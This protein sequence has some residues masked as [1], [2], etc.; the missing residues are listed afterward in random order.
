MNPSSA[1]LIALAAL[2]APGARGAGTLS[3][4]S[5]SFGGAHT[6]SVTGG[7]TVSFVAQTPMPAGALRVVLTLPS[8]G[9][10]D[11]PRGWS[12]PASPTVSFSAPSGLLVPAGGASWD[13]AA[14]R[15]RVNTT[16]AA[17]AAD[18]TVT[19]TIS[20]VV[21]PAAA[22]VFATNGT[23][24]TLL[25]NSSSSSSSA[26]HADALADG[27]ATLAAGASPIV[28]GALTGPPQW[29]MQ[30]EGEQRP[31]LAGR[32]LRVAFTA[33]SPV[34]AGGFV[35]ATLGRDDG[36]QLA[37]GFACQLGGVAQPA[38][39]DAKLRTLRVGPLTAPG[40]GAGAAAV[41]SLTGAATPV[42]VKA[43]DGSG[44]VAT[45]SPADAAIDGPSALVVP[46]VTAG[47]LVGAPTWE[48]AAAGA[49]TPGRS[50]GTLRVTFTTAGA[51]G[52]GGFVVATLSRDD[53]W[54]LAAG[55]ACQ[56]GGVA[57]PA[58]WDAKNRTLRVGPLT[59][60][61]IGAGAA[62][63]LS[64]TGAATPA[65]VT[66]A[67]AAGSV[68]TR[69]AADGVV[70]GP[71]ALT[72]PA[73]TAGAL[74]TAAEWEMAAGTHTPG[75][76]NG[77][78]HL[79]FTTLGAVPAGGF[80]VATLGRDD[81]WQLAAGFACQLGGVAQ[82]ASWDAKLRTL[83]VGPL[84][85]P[86]I[87]AGAAVS[88]SLTGAATPIEV[89]AAQFSA[90]A[91][92]F[93]TR[94]ALG[95]VVDEGRL[96]VPEVAAGA[97]SGALS[98]AM[99][100]VGTPGDPPGH[101]PGHTPGRVGVLLLN[102]TAG[103][104]VPPGGYVRAALAVP[105]GATGAWQLGGGGGG[106]AGSIGCTLRGVAQPVASADGSTLL[107]IGPLTAGIGEGEAVSL[108]LTGVGTPATVRAAS[109]AALSTESSED[110]HLVDGPT[111]ASVPALEAGALTGALLFAPDKATPGRATGA[112]AS[113]TV[114]GAVPQG[115]SV[116]LSL[117]EGWNCS[118]AAAHIV[119][120][121]FERPA[122]VA[123][124][125][126]WDAAARALTV[127]TFAAPIPQGT[128]VL[129]RVL[130]DGL[131]TPA[132]ARYAA[133]SVVV[134]TAAANG[135]AVDGPTSLAVGAVLPGAISAAVWAFR[136]A[137]RTPSVRG[138]ADL[139]FTATGAV[140][141]GAL[142]LRIAL[143]RTPATRWRLPASPTVTF[144]APA[145]LAVAAPPPC[146]VVLVAGG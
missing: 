127:T 53:G 119:S 75:R 100:A 71:S 84:T 126:L 6:P 4:V 49:H 45:R 89:K 36:W 11:P 12:M 62:V 82:P 130:G 121:N 61:G 14:G 42:D 103:G 57:Q 131:R 58:S 23:V 5:W 141:A 98:W 96:A 32:V 10:G 54:Q 79:S 108:V 44:Q 140:A 87:G 146:I 116:T 8:G 18:A 118:A 125:A 124:T 110:G 94:S 19:L 143:P 133:A 46:A 105:R 66:A 16:G 3:A 30:K 35:V 24:A 95:G 81:G 112:S 139:S 20:G 70:D 31:G 40:I 73:V 85:A 88:L 107:A 135:L 51:V 104:A 86:G 56:L 48:M 21:T 92:A 129:L 145:G 117:P 68:A 120:V 90:S 83:R 91:A 17:L 72:V 122:N 29:V 64:L 115:G 97:L 41:L 77:S 27:P 74:A 76:S 2:A 137:A 138:S 134:R 1:L 80:V 47:A 22:T 142:R 15:L 99:A 69:S 128:A 50:N 7:A 60:P 63:S 52:A 67:D 34:P 101:T 38:S 55:F 28:A 65:N 39:W 132:R 113:F 102:F 111:T 25:H 13:A 37:A 106:V 33:L 114:A 109:T 26:H 136:G 93:V 78:L 59:A 43:E 9:P 144:S 123:G